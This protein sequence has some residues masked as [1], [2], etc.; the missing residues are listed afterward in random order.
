MK[1]FQII[2]TFLFLL[3]A[4]SIQAQIYD[5]ESETSG[6]T[7]NFANGWVGT[8][9]TGFSWIADENGTGSGGTG[10]SVDHTLGNATGKYLYT[11]ASTPALPGEVATVTSPN[12][13]LAG[14]SYPALHFWYHKAGGGMGDLYVDV[15]DGMNWNNGVDSIIG[16]T[17]QNEAS[18]WLSRTVN[19]TAFSGII[20]VR[21]RAICGSSFTS[22]MAIDDI[23]IVEL[24]SYDLT[25]TSASFQG[26]SY[27]Q[28]PQ[29][30]FPYF[31]MTGSIENTGAL[32][33]T[34]AELK[35]T[36]G[37]WIDSL[38]V[39]T[40]S[41]TST[42]SFAF[43]TLP[44]LSSGLYTA[45]FEGSMDE[46]DELPS[47]NTMS[48]DFIVSDSIY[49]YDDSLAT[50]SLGIGAGTVGILGQIF[51]FYTEDTLTSVSFFLNAPTQG[52]TVIVTLHPFSGTPGAVI[53]QT[54]TLFIPSTTPAWYTLKFDCPIPLDSG[55]YFL[56]VNELNNNV[57]LGTTTLN[58]APFRN[59]V[60]F[61]GTPWTP[62]EDFGFPV[63]YLLRANLGDVSAPNAGIATSDSICAGTGTVDLFTYL[64][65]YDAGGVW[66]DDNATG[67][68][69]GSQ[70]D[71]IGINA[72]SYAFSYTV[73]DSCGLTS[74]STVTLDIF[75]VSEAGNDA[76]DSI[77]ETSNPIDLSTLLSGGQTGGTWIDQDGSGGLT[78]SMFDPSGL[79]STYNFAYV[80]NNQACN[81]DTAIISIFVDPC[82]GL[83]EHTLSDIKVYPNPSNGEFTISTEMTGNITV[84]VLDLL[85]RSL[86]T[87]DLNGN[88]GSYELS[89]NELAEG[90]YLLNISQDGRQSL[91][92]IQINK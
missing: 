51:D 78:G 54:D 14:F 82:L 45:L 62:A 90:R 88:N 59:W 84:Q 34:N 73:S 87:Y 89:L 5:F 56:G 47:N 9:T 92:M 6:A 15:F 74:S 71:P 23:E 83:N 40:L 26:V 46:T 72:G 70:V 24:P 18:P 16:T 35:I 79:S 85:G 1:H 75:E 8:P 86:G 21:F 53:A 22:D 63:T 55:V 2:T 48:F 66:S 44:A 11:E 29:S 39:P 60:S 80:V 19:L 43:N 68:L 77:C 17:H 31:G 41:T 52:D 20:Q 76:S 33:L 42:E 50:G 27:H 13:D 49:A 38:S 28:I 61:T 12:I 65:G 3:G 64:S 4:T 25:V 10:P 81:A 30:Q 67:A 36:I 37:S 91:K 69:S 7:G 57:T 58:Y 32:G